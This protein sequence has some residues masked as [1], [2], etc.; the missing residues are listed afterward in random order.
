MLKKYY[1]NLLKCL[2]DDYMTSLEKLSSV[3]KLTDQIV[4]NIVSC[5]STK[6]SNKKILDVLIFPLKDEYLLKFCDCM[7]MLATPN[8]KAVVHALRDGK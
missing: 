6:D 2:P 7:E 4:N 3:F 1:S 5:Q 8:M